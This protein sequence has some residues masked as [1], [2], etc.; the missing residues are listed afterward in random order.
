[1]KED[2][3]RW[4]KMKEDERRESLRRKK[5]QVREKVIR[6]VGKQHC[7][8]PMMCGSRRSKSRL[9]NA[10]TREMTSCTPLWREAHFQVKMYKTH[11]SRTTFGSLDIEKVHAVVHFEVKMYKA[12]H[13]RTTFGSLDVE[14]V[15]AVVTRSTFRKSKVQKMRVREHYWTFRCRFVWQARGIA[16]LVKSEQSVRFCSS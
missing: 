10:Q 15:H 5:V 3:R 4:K 16:H 14:K 9:T 7:V 13:V 2:E 1:M 11:H 8:F 6:K 12:H